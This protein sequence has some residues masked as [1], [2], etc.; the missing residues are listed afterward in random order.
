MKK[1]ILPIAIA[2]ALVTALAGFYY[3]PQSAYAPVFMERQELERS[4]SYTTPRDLQNPGKIYHKAP[5]LYVNEKYK[6]I[7]VIN[8]ANPARPVPEGFIIAP[9]CID[10]A[11]KGN[12]LYIDNAVDL[13]AFDLNARVVTERVKNIFPEPLSPDGYPCYVERPESYIL[14]GWK[15]NKITSK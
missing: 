4:V 15:Q 10:M 9:G 13:V 1:Q 8:N 5:Y 6:G 2:A 7:H 11:I 14:V 3:S 12:I